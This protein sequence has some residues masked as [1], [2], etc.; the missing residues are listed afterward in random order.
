MPTNLHLM[1]VYEYIGI[2]VV[3]LYCE[4]TL[5]EFTFS[6]PLESNPRIENAHQQLTL[7]REN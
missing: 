5:R 6:V 2:R 4:D 3:Q 7:K 1:P